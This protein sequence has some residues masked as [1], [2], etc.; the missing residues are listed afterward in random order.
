[1]KLH[2]KVGSPSPHDLGQEDILSFHST[3]LGK[4]C[5]LREEAV[6][7]TGPLNEAT[8]RI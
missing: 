4:T 8:C 3:D 6:F 2:A 5:D 1:M 7:R